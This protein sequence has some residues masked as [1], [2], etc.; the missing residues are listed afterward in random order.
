MARRSIKIMAE[1]AEAE[2]PRGHQAYWR[3]IR[4][5]CLA[6]GEVTVREVAE[7]CAA[8]RSTRATI[9]GY[10]ARLGRAGILA[11]LRV[12]AHGTTV[13]GLAEDPGPL[14]P[15]IRRDGTRYTRGLGRDH[16]WRTIGILKRFD[17]RELAIRARTEDVRVTEAA[18][19]DYCEALAAVGVLS[20]AR[21]G[22]RVV[23]TARQSA[24]TGPVA[25]SIIELRAVY[26]PNANKVLGRP[27]AREVGDG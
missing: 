21:E 9:I 23:Y 2:A 26:D 14:T 17:A 19:R 20:K 8:T 25:P 10:M 3:L 13:W 5:A 15:M 22:G 24:R 1:L 7:A 16:L 27:I 11:R 6:R 18:A 12:G 4:E